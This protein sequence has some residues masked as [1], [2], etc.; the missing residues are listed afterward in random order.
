MLLNRFM[1]DWGGPLDDRWW[2]GGNVV[3]L[4]DQSIA[5]PGAELKVPTVWRA[6]NVMA[7]AIASLPLDVFRHVDPKHPDLG[8]EIAFNEPWRTKLRR[9]PVRFQTSHRWRMHMVGR[10]LLAGN[11]YALKVG[12]PG[13]PPD[14]LFPLDPSRMKITDV[15]RDGSL[16]YQYK[17]S[18]GKDQ[19]YGQDEILHVRGYSQDGICGVSVIDLMRDTT[20]LALANR[21]Q[22]ATFVKNEMRPSVSIEAPK[23]LSDKAWERLQTGYAAAFG[24]PRNAGKVIVLEEG[25]KINP[26]QITSR[27][28]QYIE[29]EHFLI[30]EFL[31]FVGVPA[32]LVGHGDKTSTYASAEQFFQ[33]FI[34]HGV[35]PWTSNIEEELTCTLFD[36]D[37]DLFAE[38]N[39]DALLRADSTARAN[40]YKVMVELGVY[41]RNEVRALE[42]KNPLDGLGEPLT[43]LKAGGAPIPVAPE[44]APPE[45]KE[46]AAPTKVPPKAPTK[47]PGKA[48]RL[49]AGIARRLVR[50]EVSA[51]QSLA[52][53]YA[54]DPAGWA[55]QLDAFY[56]RHADLLVDDLDIDPLEAAA[57]VARQRGAVAAGLGVIETW[58]SDRPAELVEMALG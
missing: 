27:D 34:T 58:E 8:K 25:S 20:Q 28:A 29:S 39:L 15:G 40:F 56:A 24:G 46:P 57:Y 22:R 51:L 14:G 37:E 35:F 52:R 6:I 9:K 30:E 3:Y 31:R 44:P 19:T 55:E 38:F 41:T 50:K 36:D 10:V 43:P 13:Q 54:A 4:G 26:F 33:S 47:V 11:Y 18:Q 7:G 45:T 2:Q 12:A 53:R 23:A 21:V 16:T 5:G 1:A 49:A 17:T 48:E 32:V 42:N